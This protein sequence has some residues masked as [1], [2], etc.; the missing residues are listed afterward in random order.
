MSDGLAR[1]FPVAGAL[2]ALLLAGPEGMLGVVW[3]W[4]LLMVWGE[5][6]AA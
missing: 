3:V 5:C 2:A 1:R 4:T 6:A